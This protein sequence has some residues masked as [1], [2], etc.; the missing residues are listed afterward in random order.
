M[1]FVA[2]AFVA[3][4]AINSVNADITNVDPYKKCSTPSSSSSGTTTDPCAKA[5]NPTTC[6]AQLGQFGI[7][8]STNNNC[9]PTKAADVASYVTCYKSCQNAMTD[10]DAKKLVQPM[11]NCLSGSFLASV[12][13]T[14]FAIIALLF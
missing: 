14:L 2:F 10:S 4:I 7:C 6:L 3:L 12:V 11:L 1:R 13:M 9:D 5:S 8:L